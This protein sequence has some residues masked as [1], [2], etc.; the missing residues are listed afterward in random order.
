MMIGIVTGM[1]NLHADV[2]YILPDN[3]VPS[4]IFKFSLIKHTVLLLLIFI[5]SFSFLGIPLN[6]GMLIVS[7]YFISISISSVY[8]ATQTDKFSFLLNNLPHTTLIL[9]AVFV[10]ST[11]AF[12]FSNYLLKSR[13][14]SSFCYEFKNIII[15]F[16]LS[17]MLIVIAAAYEAFVL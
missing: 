14:K 5:N 11:A 15:K 1:L 9:S 16:I 10:L 4:Y 13:Y 6:A 3:S 12:E 8:I 2:S 17:I 7:G